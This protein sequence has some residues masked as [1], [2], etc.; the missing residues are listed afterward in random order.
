MMT[1]MGVPVRAEVQ[2]VLS[3]KQSDSASHRIETLRIYLENR[4]GLEPFLASYR[5]LK[6][7]GGADSSQADDAAA[8]TELEQLL[9]GAHQLT[10]LPVLLQLLA[11]EERFEEM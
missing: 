1:L 11:V 4:L 3:L 5:Y 8:T 7:M 2:A 9:G 10:H 6:R